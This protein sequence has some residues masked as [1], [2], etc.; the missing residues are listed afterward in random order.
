MEGPVRWPART[1]TS[2]KTKFTTGFSS[3]GPHAA[4]GGLSAAPHAA[5]DDLR[6]AA[7]AFPGGLIVSPDA[8][9]GGLIV[10]PDAVPGEL[11]VFSDAVPDQFPAQRGE[12]L[13]AR[14]QVVQE[15]VG[16]QHLT[17]PTL[18]EPRGRPLPP[19][20]IAIV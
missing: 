19:V 2:R 13:C 3:S 15:A 16:P 5:P 12:E 10:S 18:S 14:H 11:H 20:A 4:S 17:Q 6:V 1:I 7:D 8:V 9:P